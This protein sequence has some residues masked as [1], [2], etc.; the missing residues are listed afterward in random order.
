M[1]VKDVKEGYNWNNF[2]EKAA[3]VS[4]TVLSWHKGPR[5]RR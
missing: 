5:D 2:Q 3:Q 4:Y 1:E